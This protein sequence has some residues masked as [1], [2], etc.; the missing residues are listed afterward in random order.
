MFA[1]P[2]P[3]EQDFVREMAATACDDAWAPTTP[4]WA[5]DNSYLLALRCLRHAALIDGCPHGLS[6]ARFAATMAAEGAPPA[7]AAWL[8]L[9]RQEGQE[10]A[11]W[12]EQGPEAAAGAEGE[13]D[14][15][16]LLL[17]AALGAMLNHQP[18]R[19]AA[20]F[21]LAPLPADLPSALL[22]FV[23]SLPP[24][25]PVRAGGW[26][27][28]RAAAPAVRWVPLV[29]VRSDLLVEPGASAIELFAAYGTDPCSL[30]YHP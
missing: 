8:S 5:L 21:Q 3:S 22:R 4:A 16:P 19:R 11:G 9:G 17:Q 10:P 20:I 28:R 14:A 24:A 23:P 15:E 13:S 2:H 12:Q 18:D 26:R 6:A 27:A 30:G 7:N 29:L 25:A 1:R